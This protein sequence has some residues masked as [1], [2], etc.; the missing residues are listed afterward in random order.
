[1][2]VMITKKYVGITDIMSNFLKKTV[3]VAVASAEEGTTKTQLARSIYNAIQRKW[4]RNDYW[5]VI[6][7][8][9]PEFGE[10]ND[11]WG[12]YVTMDEHKYIKLQLGDKLY[13]EIWKGSSRRTN[14]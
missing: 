11:V 3:A 8:S 4:G 13:F 14:K 9:T 1:M 12:S 7:A 2:Q 5:N 10:G 6:V